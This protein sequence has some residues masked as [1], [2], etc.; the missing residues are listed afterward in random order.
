MSRPRFLADH[1]LNEHILLGLMRREPLADILRAREAGIADRPD[2]EVLAFAAEQGR[3]VLSHDV[4]T[5]TAAARQRLA[6]RLPMAGL[7]LIRQ[8]D[9]MGDILDSLVLVWSATQ[10]EEWTGVMAFLPF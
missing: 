5:M 4:N 9:P 6:G 1:D 10:A 7:L 2:D 3:I 8:G